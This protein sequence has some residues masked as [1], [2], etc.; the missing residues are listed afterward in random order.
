[1]CVCVCVWERGMGKAL[2]IMLFLCFFGFV[3]YVQLFFFL[4][5]RAGVED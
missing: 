4:I 1:M 3:A 5:V 2:F